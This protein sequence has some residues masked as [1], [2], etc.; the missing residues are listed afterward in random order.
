MWKAI[1]LL[2]LGVA[3]GAAIFVYQRLESPRDASM[4]AVRGDASV[5]DLQRS[6]AALD[7]RVQDLAAQVEM[8][9]DARGRNSSASS[10]PTDEAVA[11]RNPADPRPRFEQGREQ[12]D[13]AT[14]R[15]RTQQRELERITAAGLTRERYNA[16]TRREEEL[17]V[18]A[19]QAQYESQRS[20]QG[21]AGV[22]VDMAL[23]RELGDADYERYLRAQGRAT[24]VRVMEVLATSA[25]ERSGLQAGDEILSYGGTRVFAARDLNALTMMSN[26]GGPVTVE[27][28]RGNQTLQMAVPS[29]PLGVTAGAGGRS[30]AGGPG[31]PAGPGGGFRGGR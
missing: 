28:R 14:L 11:T 1:G 20:G 5:A 4:V 30:Q 26:P 16:I 21:G 23:R 31:G 15:E 24:T 7:Q 27:V 6:L 29:G 8:L 9:R 18:A 12:P 2:A 13:I 10:L 25:A 19:M 22:D 17:R 3:A